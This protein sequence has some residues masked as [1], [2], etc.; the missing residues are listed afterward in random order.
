MDEN[1]LVELIK[2]PFFDHFYSNVFH[3]SDVYG[4]S[5]L[6]V[7]YRYLVILVPVYEEIGILRIV[8]TNKYLKVKDVVSLEQPLS[9]VS[10]SKRG[11]QS[12]ISGGIPENLALPTAFVKEYKF[13]RN[14]WFSLGRPS[15][16]LISGVNKIIFNLKTTGKNLLIFSTRSAIPERYGLSM[17]ILLIRIKQSSL[18]RYVTF[19][20]K[21]YGK[22]PPKFYSVD[23]T[24]FRLTSRGEL[25]EI[26]IVLSFN[27]DDFFRHKRTIKDEL[28]F[29]KLVLVSNRTLGELSESDY[30][31]VLE[32]LPIDPYLLCIYY[33]TSEKNK[34]PFLI[35]RALRE[36]VKSQLIKTIGQ[37]ISEVISKSVKPNGI[38]EIE[39]FED[40]L[41][42]RVIR[43]N[44][45]AKFLFLYLEGQNRSFCEDFLKSSQKIS[46]LD[47]LNK[48]VNT[49]SR[50]LPSGDFMTRQ[51]KLMID[52]IMKLDS[53]VD[54]IT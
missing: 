12:Y 47:A 13:L 3:Y 11:V 18:D 35:E 28:C 53:E 48:T 2:V 4:P 29:V 10:L 17:N 31:I 8:S 32:I 33:G 37:D 30:N 36:S 49:S 41:R 40:G 9:K 51:L 7:P 6:R 34:A 44:V 26:P 42:V 25:Q 38:A 52:E 45:L 46:F 1:N 50:F 23:C 16:E 5:N 21:N 20:P 24:T 43:L 15:F 22:S 54:P 27:E 39:Q 19:Y 14:I